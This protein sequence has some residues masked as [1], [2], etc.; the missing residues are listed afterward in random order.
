MVP[1]QARALAVVL[2]ALA[3]CGCS[4]DKGVDFID[5]DPRIFVAS[6]D[7]GDRPRIGYVGRLVYAAPSRCLYYQPESGDRQIPV[8]PK[9]TKVINKDGKRGVNIPGF[10]DLLDGE[11][12]STGAGGDPG[13]LPKDLPKECI[14]SGGPVF[15]NEFN[16]VK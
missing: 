12:F 4:G 15:S 10:G 11:K 2:C 9:G 8:W 3:V 13:K 6:S 7:D 5:D 1:I 16:R 14:P